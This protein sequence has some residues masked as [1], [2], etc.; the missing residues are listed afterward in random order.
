MS[1]HT[2]GGAPRV[3]PSTIYAGAV[4]LGLVIVGTVALALAGWDSQKIAGLWTTAGAGAALF[5]PIL[6]R[7]TSLWQ[8]T[9]AQTQTLQTI[10][11]NTNG[12]LAAKINDAID[13]AVPRIAR[14]VREAWDEPVGY[15]PTDTAPAGARPRYDD[16]AAA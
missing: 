11:H 4:L 16:G 13:A 10:Q 2:T 15:M 7:V 6:N 8:E 1:D 3:H 9:Q 5:L 12:V 14:A